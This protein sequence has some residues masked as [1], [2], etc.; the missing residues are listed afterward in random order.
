MILRGFL[1]KLAIAKFLFP[2][3]HLNSCSPQLHLSNNL[4]FQCHS[5]SPSPS[6]Q[7]MRQSHSCWVSLLLPFADQQTHSPSPGECKPPLSQWAARPHN[8]WISINRSSAE[9][10]GCTQLYTIHNLH[11]MI[12]NVKLLPWL[13]SWIKIIRENTSSQSS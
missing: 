12:H 1:H 7:Q 10:F 6:L 9:I 11:L 2:I 4:P 13:F 5:S 3:F 8:C